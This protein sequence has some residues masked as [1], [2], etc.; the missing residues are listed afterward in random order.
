MSGPHPE[1]VKRVLERANQLHIPLEQHIERITQSYQHGGVQGFRFNP[2]DYD[3]LQEHIAAAIKRMVLKA[4]DYADKVGAFMG[5]DAR[6]NGFSISA[7]ERNATNSLHIELAKS[8]CDVHLDSR[9]ITTGHQGFPFWGGHYDPTRLG[10]HFL[11]DLLPCYVADYTPS[12]APFVNPVLKRLGYDLGV[13]SKAPSLKALDGSD[14]IGG[15]ARDP[16]GFRIGFSLTF[17]HGLGDGR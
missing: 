1:A 5:S 16:E 4:D 15:P 8:V 11:N 12:L 9:S 10:P 6:K 3:K 7:R 14:L 17:N 2:K 13:K